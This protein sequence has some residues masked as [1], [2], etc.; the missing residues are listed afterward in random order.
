MDLFKQYNIYNYKMFNTNNARNVQE[1]FDNVVKQMKNSLQY[2]PLAY[3]FN[4][5]HCSCCYPSEQFYIICK[6]GYEFKILSYESK[7]NHEKNCPS[8]ILPIVQC[9]C[10]NPFE[11]KNI[12]PFEKDDTF[13]NEFNKMNSFTS[14]YDDLWHEE[15]EKYLNQQKENNAIYE[16]NE[17]ENE[18]ENENKVK[19]YHYYF[20]HNKMLS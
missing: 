4:C 19:N 6:T 1:A 11:W 14:F 16:Y 15:L 12:I 7:Y 2:T 8:M 18:T 5:Y 3:Q 10:Y 13:F 9:D 20:L 17:N